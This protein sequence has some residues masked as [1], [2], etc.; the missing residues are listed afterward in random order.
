MGIW[1][2]I[3]GDLDTSSRN[4]PQRNESKE[5]HM[6]EG[7]TSPHNPI[8]CFTMFPNPSNSKAARRAACQRNQMHPVEKHLPKFDVWVLGVPSKQEGKK[9]RG[10]N[11]VI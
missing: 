11:V 8:G 4:I 9:G 6:Q 10:W 5:N 7:K 1:A 2:K 3:L